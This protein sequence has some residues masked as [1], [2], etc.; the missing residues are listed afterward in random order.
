MAVNMGETV[1]SEI[2]IYNMYRGYALAAVDGGHFYQNSSHLA[3]ALKIFPG[4]HF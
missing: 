2:I 3:P 1:I 4:L